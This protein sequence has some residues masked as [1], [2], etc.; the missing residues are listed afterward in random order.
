MVSVLRHT[1]PCEREKSGGTAQLSKILRVS[2]HGVPGNPI[3]VPDKLVHLHFS[4]WRK[5]PKA[6]RPPGF[7]RQRGPPHPHPQE[8]LWPT[9][10][11]HT[12]ATS[13]TGDPAVWR[14]SAAD[15]Q[16]QA[17]PEAE[18]SAAGGAALWRLQQAQ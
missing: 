13:P 14:L 18:T 3:P 8:L 10:R 2:A 16:E 9:G 11:C 7:C 12:Q 5:K 4:Q 1:Y 17:D 15:T 6:R